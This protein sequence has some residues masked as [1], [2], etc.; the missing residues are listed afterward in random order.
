MNQFATSETNKANAIN[1]N[2][3][4][5]I[6]QANADREA[7][8][9]QFNSQLKDNREKFNVENQRVIDQSN[10]QWRRQINTANTAAANAAAQTN[11]QN[12]LNMSNFALS[13][14]WQQWRDEATWTNDAAQNGLNRAHNIAMAALER[15][16]EFDLMDKA[17]GDKIF[18]LIG[19]FISGVWDR[20]T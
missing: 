20:E 13:S 17:N 7:A 5:A 16:T 2:N 4:T 10:T 12:L 15:Q 19:K 18:D 1:A 9:N 8:I 3:S 6:A 11:A 14:M